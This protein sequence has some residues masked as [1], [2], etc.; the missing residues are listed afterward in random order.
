MYLRLIL[1]SCLSAFVVPISTSSSLSYV[2]KTLL[3]LMKYVNYM[4]PGMKI[5]FTSW[6]SIAIWRFSFVL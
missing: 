2:L 6:S 1:N 3:R 4:S 5:C